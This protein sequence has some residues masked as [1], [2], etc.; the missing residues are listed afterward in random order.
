MPCHP[1]L[2]QETI[3]DRASYSH[4]CVHC[5]SPDLEAGV[6]VHRMVREAIVSSVSKKTT[7]SRWM[8]VVHILFSAPSYT[9]LSQRIPIMMISILSESGGTN[10]YIIRIP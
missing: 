1:V 2:S 8:R 3:M 7:P 4:R 10:R 5:I 6:Q 9:S